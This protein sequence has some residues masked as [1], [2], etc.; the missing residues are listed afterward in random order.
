MKALRAG[1]HVYMQKPLSG[2]MG[3]ADAFVTAGNTGAVVASAYFRLGTIPGVD[4]P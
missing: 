4:L 3:E 1:K 2:D